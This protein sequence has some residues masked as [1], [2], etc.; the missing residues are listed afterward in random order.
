MIWGIT[1]ELA[2]DFFIKDFSVVRVYANE[3]SWD[4]ASG[5][6]CRRFLL[7]TIKG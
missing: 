1:Q 7:E 2:N 5:C 4:F 3:K 6:G